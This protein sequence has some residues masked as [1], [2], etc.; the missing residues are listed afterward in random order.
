M[1]INRKKKEKNLPTT[2]KY[3]T[4]LIIGFVLTCRVKENGKCE[5][6]TENMNEKDKS[7]THKSM[8]KRRKGR[9]RNKINITDQVGYS[10]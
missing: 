10:K 7:V 1:N 5:I 9:K 4:W 3:P 8:Q 2:C 6:E